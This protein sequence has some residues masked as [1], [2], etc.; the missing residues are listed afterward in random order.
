MAARGTNLNS[1]DFGVIPQE[2]INSP[3]FKEGRA[4]WSPLYGQH[5]PPRHILR[6]PPDDKNARACR[7][8]GRSPCAVEEADVGAIQRRQPWMKGAPSKGLGQL[9]G[10]DGCRGNQHH[11]VPYSNPWGNI[12]SSGSRTGL[13]TLWP[14]A[15]TVRRSCPASRARTTRGY[16]LRRC[17]L[18]SAPGA[19]AG[20][21][22]APGF[23]HTAA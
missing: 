13:T 20:R 12:A 23:Q 10:D 18:T 6:H 16:G 8:I 11:R 22:E 9:D 1:T 14:R 3:T 7:T 19:A 2:D 21:S 17:A 5:E 4:V 15:R